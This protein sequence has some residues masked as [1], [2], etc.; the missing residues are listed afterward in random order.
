MPDGHEHIVIENLGV[1][2]ELLGVDVG[3]DNFAVTEGDPL[4][5]IASKVFLGH[6]SPLLSLNIPNGH[7]RHQCLVG[8]ADIW[9]H[10][11]SHLRLP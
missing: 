4:A 8:L 7:D 2:L 3:G 6:E 11:K 10:V 5:R 1:L 9:L